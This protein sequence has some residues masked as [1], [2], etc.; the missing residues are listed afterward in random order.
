MS[1]EDAL[2]SGAVKST[3]DGIPMT[4]SIA[5]LK[6]YLVRDCYP[7][8]YTLLMERLVVDTMRYVMLTG[9]PGIGKSI[10]YMYF[11]DRY[12]REHSSENI[13]LAAF[14]PPNPETGTGPQ[15]LSCVMWNATSKEFEELKEVPKDPKVCKLHLYDGIPGV[16]VSANLGI[17]MVTFTSPNRD[18]IKMMLKHGLSFTAIYM[19]NWTLQ[20]QQDGR[21]TLQLNISNAALLESWNYF[22]GTVR[23]TL[24]TAEAQFQKDQIF[25]LVKGAKQD[26]VDAIASLQ[27]ATAVKDCLQGDFS[28]AHVRHRIFHYE[29]NRSN[30][31]EFYPPF[32]VASRY[33]ASEIYSHLT[34]KLVEGPPDE[35]MD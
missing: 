9:T 34:T 16:Y 32:K 23:Y 30:R 1:G 29:I 22:G 5:S 7:E 35:I 6:S 2:S 20:E 28:N 14:S 26:V 31:G 3:I 12:R 11:F 18:W 27:D 33:I 19:P 13:V 17:K 10:F 25:Q 4:H 24:K 15:L 8:Y 21:D